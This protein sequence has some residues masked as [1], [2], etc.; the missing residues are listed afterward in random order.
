MEIS[1][2]FLKIEQ[3]KIQNI[4]KI[5]GNRN[6]KIFFS[7]TLPEKKSFIFNFEDENIKVF[8]PKISGCL[9]HEII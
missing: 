7:K 2:S 8:Y 3:Q 4:L 1:N 9:S 5:F 6:E